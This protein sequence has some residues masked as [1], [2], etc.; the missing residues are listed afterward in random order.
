MANMLPHS[1][2]YERLDTQETS[3][4][5]QRWNALTSLPEAPIGASFERREVVRKSRLTSYVIF[6]FTVMVVALLPVC[7]LSPYPSYF[8]LDLGLTAACFLGLALN[9][10]GFTKTAGVFVTAA[11]FIVLTSALFSTIPFDE[12]TLQGYDMYIIVEMLAVSLLPARSVFIFLALSVSSILLT[13]FTMKHS[14]ALDIDIRTRLLIILARPIGTLFLGSSVAYILA[15]HLTQAI[16]HAQQVEE[17]AKLE[18]A[19]RNYEL[20]KRNEALHHDIQQI[21]ATHIAV[22]N[23][24][25][26]ARAPLAKDNV[27]WQ[28]AQ[29]LNTLLVR[30]Q[31][32]AQGE[33]QLQQVNRAIT[34]YITIIQQAK[35]EQKSPFLPVRRTPIDPLVVELQGVT[36]GLMRPGILGVPLRQPPEGGEGKDS[37]S[38]ANLNIDI[39][40]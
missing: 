30:Y 37:R 20:V 1:S 31:R 40:E 9:G 5:I 17:I 23:G 22:A 32:A 25:H 8:W 34:D 6:F 19:E 12:T 10:K 24:N 26:N 4:L 27:L 33:H 16:R 3:G 28:I 7:Y 29:S 35:Q 18:E 2:L 13:F 38:K 36:V 14:V 21:L 39:W 11:A 15:S